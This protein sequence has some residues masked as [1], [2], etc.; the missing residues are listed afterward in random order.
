MKIS[1]VYSYNAQIKSRSI[2]YGGEP[3]PLG[4]TKLDPLGE[5]GCEYENAVHKQKPSNFNKS[6]DSFEK[7]TS[8]SR[9]TSPLAYRSALVGTIAGLVIGG[10]FMAY[11]IKAGYLAEN[12]NPI[13]H[14]YM[15]NQKVDFCK[16]DDGFL[17]FVKEKLL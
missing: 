6:E 10:A 8:R 7:T 14:D 17:Q 15:E 12:T 4:V 13:R 9:K 5:D 1:P 2:S 3:H 11:K 16:E